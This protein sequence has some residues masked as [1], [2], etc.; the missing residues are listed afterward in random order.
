[1]PYKKIP[2]PSP[3]PSPPPSSSTDDTRRNEAMAAAISEPPV[4]I[5]PDLQAILKKQVGAHVRPPGS[6]SQTP[7]VPATAYYV[8][9]GYPPD[10]MSTGAALTQIRQASTLGLNGIVV[11]C[12]NPS[13]PPYA[14]D[15]EFLRATRNSLPPGFS[16]LVW[17]HDGAY[18]VLKISRTCVIAN[19][20]NAAA[21]LGTPERQVHDGARSVARGHLPE[22]HG[23]CAFGGCPERGTE[24]CPRCANVVACVAHISDV[25]KCAGDA[26][27]VPHA[28]CCVSCN[29]MLI[30]NAGCVNAA[31]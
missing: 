1:M 17:R 28:C 24:K 21:K 31:L 26:D 4:A 19:R 18:A 9:V 15:H 3:S 10:I 12:V 16:W 8:C 2:S 25:D 11:T 27:A 14:L 6:A 7:P 20:L 30:C 23:M 13:S 29:R 5:D 22:V